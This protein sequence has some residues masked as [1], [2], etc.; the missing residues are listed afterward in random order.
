MTD[1]FSDFVKIPLATA[2]VSFQTLSSRAK[3]ILALVFMA[4][5]ICYVL[6]A[7]QGQVYLAYFLLLLN[8]GPANLLAQ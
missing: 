6:D 8:D 3:N 4:L 1:M 2:S 7:D 5:L